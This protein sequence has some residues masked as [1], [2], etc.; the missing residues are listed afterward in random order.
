MKSAVLAT[1]VVALALGLP[2]WLAAVGD[3][4][5]DEVRV[6]ARDLRLTLDNVSFDAKSQYDWEVR[7]KLRN[8][9]TV[10]VE[11]QPRQLET[12][13][14]D[15]RFWLVGTDHAYRLSPNWPAGVPTSLPPPVVIEPGASIEFVSRV[16]LM[17][18]SGFRRGSPST[19]P[20]V[21]EFV[22]RMEAGQY[23]VDVYIEVGLRVNG[24][25]K[26]QYVWV[27]SCNKKWIKTE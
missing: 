2:A 20:D 26:S 22:P 13:G 27:P 5:P 8:L 15:V 1:G 7:Y 25:G 11:V 6:S 3:K 12:A 18:G 19:N 10:S 9:A 16:P 17:Q 21:E 24:Q 23:A 4:P 14:G